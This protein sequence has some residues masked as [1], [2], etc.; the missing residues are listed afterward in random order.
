[1]NVLHIIHSLDP[2][3]GGPSH[4][5][6]GLVRAQSEIGHS[7][8]VIATDRQSGEPWEEPEGFLEQV[9]SYLPPHLCQLTVIPSYGRKNLWLRYG[10]S[11]VCRRM[12]R[13]SLSQA[14]SSA[15]PDFVHVHGVFSQITQLATQIC[16]KKGIPYALRPTGALNPITLNKGARLWK[17]LFAHLLL[18]TSLNQAAFVHATSAQEAASLRSHDWGNNIRVIPLGIRPPRWEPK[19]YQN[20]FAEL[21]PKLSGKKFILCLSRIHPI[22]RLDLALLSFAEFEK[23]HPGYHLVIAGDPTDYQVRLQQLVI[24]LQIID[25]VHFIGFLDGEPK[26]G[27]FFSAEAFLQTSEHENFG[28]TVMEAL[29]HGLSVI[30]TK[31]V[32]SGSH[33]EA[34]QGGRRTDD[35]PSAI[36][37]AM[38]T[39]L[40]MPTSAR[41]KVLANMVSR[42]F[43]WNEIATNLD[44]H[45]L[46]HI[47]LTS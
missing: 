5:L 28:M 33:V 14:K 9:K 4:A 18:E 38:E 45:M 32:A 1:M 19:H 20:I 40:S 7:V 13:Q 3:S 31:G 23:N 22:K 15:K 25:Q 12:L 11:P 24:E 43:S 16:R 44:T 6:Y 39:V 36:T 42:R 8:S 46:P 35:T 10:Y 17:K 37:E 29:A 21:F 47:N 41:N 30:C 26:S 34:L 2:R 27:A